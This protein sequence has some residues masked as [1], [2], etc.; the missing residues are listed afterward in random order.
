[1]RRTIT[2]LSV[3]L[4]AVIF[5]AFP[6]GAVSQTLRPSSGTNTAGTVYAIAKVGADV[7]IGGS[8]TSVTSTNGTTHAAGGLA[9]LNAS[10]G[11]WVWSASLGGT[12]YA[13]GTDGTNLFAGGTYGVRRL[14]LAGAQQPF[15]MPYQVGSVRALA[16]GAGRVF[17]GGDQGVAAATTTG[18]A[19]WRVVA[20]SV[21]SLAVNG[22]QLLVGGAFCTIGGVARTTLASLNAN[23]SVSTGF[24][25]HVFTCTDNV[26]QPALGIAVDSGRAYVAGGGTLNRVIAVNATTGAVIWQAKHGDGDVQAVAVQGGAVYIGGHFDCVDGTDNHPCNAVR[27]KAARYST[28]G[29]LDPTWA[30]TF[31][32]GP[33]G[34]WA[35]AGDATQLYVGGAFTR[36]NGAVRN[37]VAIFAGSSFGDGS[38]AAAGS[39]PGGSRARYRRIASQ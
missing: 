23:G 11:A 17:Y 31:A 12:T 9:A 2:I 29:V 3:A 5:L 27:F 20:T 38:L 22:T 19:V 34:V 28:D 16:V 30:P 21:R 39:A 18:G 6:A 4:G 25:A 10:T 24:N 1:M 36:I 13:L 8:F 14:T 35:L 37:K 15:S 33:L 32:G 26:G 7:V